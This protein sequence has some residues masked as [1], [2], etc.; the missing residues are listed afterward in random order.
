MRVKYQAQS[1]K[2][3]F[4]QLS[5]PW[6]TQDTLKKCLRL[7]FTSI[8]YDL[9]GLGYGL[10]FGSFKSNSKVDRNM[11]ITDLAGT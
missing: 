10:A 11:G 6:K 9:I 2:Q 5:A 8:D 7:S 1:P 4:S 3:W